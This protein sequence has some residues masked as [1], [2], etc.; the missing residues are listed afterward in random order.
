[1]TDDPF[2]DLI[3]LSVSHVSFGTSQ[4]L[5]AFTPDEELHSDKP[6]LDLRVYFQEITSIA[7]DRAG[8][9]STVMSKDL[10]VHG[11]LTAAER[12]GDS[13]VL[14]GGFGRIEISAGE[15]IRADRDH[16][17]ADA[18]PIAS[19]CEPPHACAGMK[20]ALA[21]EDDGMRY[22]PELREYG[23]AYVVGDPSYHLISHC[24]FCGAELPGGL[25][26]EWFDRLEALGLDPI[27]DLPEELTTDRWWRDEGIGAQVS[28]HDEGS[29][30]VIRPLG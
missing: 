29:G 19:E 6:S 4:G 25:R 9:E 2:R 20:Q 8:A 15:V 1:M 11:R 14:V 16:E 21:D 10:M 7:W 17:R 3:G 12:A 18:V 22:V 23:Y 13:W 26:D 5:V 30:R 24:P 28:T 27:D